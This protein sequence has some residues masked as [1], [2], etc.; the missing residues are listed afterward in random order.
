MFFDEAVLIAIIVGLGEV[1]KGLGLSDKYVPILSLFLGLVGGILFL[2][3]G[4]LSS[5]IIMGLIMGLSAVGLYSGS[6]NVI[7]AVNKE[8]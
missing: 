5:G 6:K 3:P 2:F 1:A 7:E 4:D 8:D